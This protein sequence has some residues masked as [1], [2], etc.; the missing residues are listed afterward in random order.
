M[1][2]RRPSGR[3]RSLR[4]PSAS[5]GS[6]GTSLDA[7]LDDLRVRSSVQVSGGAET[8]QLPYW[9]LPATRELAVSGVNSD[10]FEPWLRLYVRSESDRWI[11]SDGGENVSVIAECNPDFDANSEEFRSYLSARSVSLNSAGALHIPSASGHSLGRAISLLRHVIV[12]L[13]DQFTKSVWDRYRASDDGDV[14]DVMDL[15]GEQFSFGDLL[16]EAGRWNFPSAVFGKGALAVAMEWEGNSSCTVELVRDDPG[17]FDSSE[18][19]FSFSGSGNGLGLWRVSEGEWRDPHPGV[20]YHLE[21]EVGGRGEFS[22]WM[23]IPELGQSAVSL[24]YYADG[25]GGATMAGPFRVGARPL[26]ANLR[27]DGGGRFFVELVS[28]DGADEC[29]V[30]ST[31]GQV[32]LDEYPVAVKPGKEYLLYAGAGGRWEIE[33]TEG[34]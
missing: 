14:P 21:V 5:S 30:V 18:A 2:S 32:H 11:V 13:D 15:S 31:D 19:M 23:L 34:F 12:A 33:L 4:D 24:P 20:S 26:L 27:H 6:S 3:R 10:D 8:L 22:C 17:I 9:S 25:Y 1:V 16:P 29:T 7:Y 28:L